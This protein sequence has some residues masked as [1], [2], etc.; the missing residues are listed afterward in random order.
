ME[1]TAIEQEANTVLMLYNETVH[2]AQWELAAKQTEGEVVPL[3]VIVR[4][5][6]YG[7]I[8]RTIQ[9]DY[10]MRTNEI[11]PRGGFSRVIEV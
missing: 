5:H 1:S 3:E 4:K 6:K 8:N 11:R 10:R 2:R 7:A 9:L